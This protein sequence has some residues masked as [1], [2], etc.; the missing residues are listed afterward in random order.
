MTTESSPQ[1]RVQQTTMLCYG[2]SGSLTPCLCPY[3]QLPSTT[4]VTYKVPT[5][6]SDHPLICSQPSL[7]LPFLSGSFRFLVTRP[8]DPINKDYSF[9]ST[10]HSSQGCAFI[11]TCHTTSVLLCIP[12]KFLL[13]PPEPA[14]SEKPPVTTD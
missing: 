6:C 7:R 9:Q 13:I 3:L 10:S 5:I 14:F 1:P 12:D 4:V 8:Q 2:C 11:H